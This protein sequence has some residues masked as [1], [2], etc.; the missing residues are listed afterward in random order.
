MLA[1]RE[2]TKL[3][4]G[5]DYGTTYSGLSFAYSNAT[6]FKDIFPWTK[7][8]GSS[9]HGAEHCVKAP[10]QVAFADENPELEENAWG[11]QVEAGYDSLFSVLRF[12]HYLTHNHH[13][14]RTCAWTKLLL[15]KSSL[16]SV[17]DDPDLYLSQGMD[18]LHLPKGRSAKDVATEY[19]KGMKRMFDTAVKEHLGAQNIDHLPIDFWLTVPASWS[20]KAKMLTKSAATDAGFATRPID[21][22]MLIS[23]PEAAAQLALKSSLHRLEDFVKVCTPLSAE[24]PGFCLVPFLTFG[25]PNTGVMICDCGGGTVV[26][27]HDVLL[28]GFWLTADIVPLGYH[29][30]RSRRDATN[31]EAQRDSN[32]YRYVNHAEFV[33]Y[34]T[35]QTTPTLTGYSSS[36]KVWRNLC[37]QKP[38]QIAG[39]TLW[40]C[41]YV[42]RS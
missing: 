36:W 11:Y 8:P 39:T 33:C 10:T 19:L 42:T 37:G 6:D 13:R 38:L 1:I 30:L 20:E 3:I 12:E 26:G 9:S 18:I 41:L 24:W 29:H 7:Y 28:H 22:I 32:W 16:A 2:K 21:R 23:E 27:F 34:D 40:R 4:V 31:F 5:I 25:Q 17:H 35:G 15:D 14:M